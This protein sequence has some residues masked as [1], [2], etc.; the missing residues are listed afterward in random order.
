MNVKKPFF[1]LLVMGSLLASCSVSKVARMDR[2]VIEGNWTLNNVSYEGNSGKFKSVL[3]NDA[4]ANC[5]IGSHWFFRNNNSTGS[6]WLMDGTD[7]TGGDRF[8]RWSVVDRGGLPNQLQFK[9]I[10]EKYKDISGGVGYRLDIASLTE[11]QMTLKSKVS[12]DG[13]PIT[14]VYKF[15]K[16]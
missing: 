4:N 16:E 8:I 12:V 2:K 6:Y 13:E 14:I 9:F 7:C 15:S 11:E 1:A 3:F 10:D 5:F